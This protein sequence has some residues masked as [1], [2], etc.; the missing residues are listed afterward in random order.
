[1]NKEDI[2]FVTKIVDYG[3][4]REFVKKGNKIL[5]WIEQYSDNIADDDKKGECFFALGKPSQK[6]PIRYRY[7]TI[8]KAREKLLEALNL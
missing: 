1:M 2:T 6:H 5:G 7:N 8:E 4:R 3:I